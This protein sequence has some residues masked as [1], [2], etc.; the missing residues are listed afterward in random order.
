MVGGAVPGVDDLETGYPGA[1]CCWITIVDMVEGAVP[2]VDDL[3]T[4]YAGACCC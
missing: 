1:C 3:E 4:E 2:A